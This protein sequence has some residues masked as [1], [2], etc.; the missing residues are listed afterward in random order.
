MATEM[1][2]KKALDKVTSPEQLDMLMQVT[3]PKGW[4]AL[5]GFGLIIVLAIVWSLMANIATTVSAS[6]MIVPESG[7]TGV[8]APASGTVAS[9]L[10]QSNQVVK[11][12]QPVLTMR[13]GHGQ[14]T[15]VAPQ[16]GRVLN[17]SAYPGAYVAAG[18][19]IASVEPLS[20]VLETVFYLPATEVT[21]VKPG[22]SVHV[23]PLS[24]NQESNGYLLG[25]VAKV[26][27]YPATAQ[28]AL[29]IFQNPSIT[30]QLVGNSTAY[31]VVVDLARRPTS[32][33]GYAWSSGSGPAS[34]LEAGTFASGSFIVSEQH[35]IGLLFK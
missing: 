21:L 35:P 3:T 7:M 14:V 32:V 4:F 28:S 6:G 13:V 33:S 27:A 23:E 8:T 22:I 11:A 29:A 9:V 26:S 31:E 15:V 19:P 24:A 2:R 5:I 18:S 25:T 10:V 20:T 17:V 34:P 16:G 1:Y 30:S 12:G